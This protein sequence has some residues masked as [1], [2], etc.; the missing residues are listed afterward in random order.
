M[1]LT[2]T[3]T[4]LHDVPLYFRNNAKAKI[5]EQTEKRYLQI[6]R[7]DKED[8]PILLCFAAPGT[9]KSRLAESGAKFLSESK[10]D[11]LRRMAQDDTLA[12]HISFNGNT[13]YDKETDHKASQSLG[14]R[15]LS[16][17]FGFDW[18]ILKGGNFLS[19]LT[20]ESCL[21]AVL[22][23]HRRNF[24]ADAP[25][26]I[27]YLAVDDIGGIYPHRDRET[28]S[29]YLAGEMD[30]ASEF[31]K[32]L[33]NS[34]GSILITPPQN[35]FCVA[36]ITGTTY[37]PVTNILRTS[38]HPYVNV[39]VPLLPLQEAMALV[40]ETGVFPESLLAH[41]EFVRLMAD[42]GGI[43][44]VL[45]WLLDFFS[46]H[47]A[48]AISKELFP[49]LISQARVSVQL[50]FERRYKIDPP[51]TYALM[52]AA[53]LRTPVM[54][55]SFVL[56]E[57]GYTYGDLESNGS[58][59]LEHDQTTNV[60]TVAVPLIAMNLWIKYI[61]ETPHALTKLM[62]SKDNDYFS[63]KNFE[64]FCALYESLLCVMHSSNDK[65]RDVPL[66]EFYRGAR[67]S[68]DLSGTSLLLSSD[69]S[70][71][72]YQA[73][74]RFPDTQSVETRDAFDASFKQLEEGSIIL[75][76]DGA[77]CD[78]LA[79]TEAVTRDGAPMQL[80]RAMHMKHT[81]DNL[82]LTNETI[83]S[84]FERGQKMIAKVLDIPPEQQ[85]SV[86]L[87]NRIVESDVSASTVDIPRSVIVTRDQLHGFFGVTFAGRA[88]AMRNTVRTPS[89]KYSTWRVRGPIL[90]KVLRRM[91]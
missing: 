9:G 79:K 16:S 22:L 33:T 77:K 49:T 65:A 20:L 88:S 60:R 24:P 14:L 18:G 91:R 64:E 38:A 19:G 39:G 58:I 28:I 6:G 81:V 12:I 59:F 41:P 70:Y 63:W 76:A 53:I 72:V 84:E 36:L 46:T 67:V 47:S 62:Q 1:Q 86:F 3:G 82:P 51:Y 5:L 27:L 56:R 11:E 55:S 80:L 61:H 32:Q 2:S 21:Q 15:V 17:Y 90:L 37:I 4:N 69:R 44:R 23:H 7:G 34:V 43:P 85:V 25:R 68:E 66:T 35:S 78:I 42:I 71:D 31:V 73:R 87:S 54:M 45:E 57:D 48:L 74:S 40:Q 50:I 13:K 52:R 75:N 10:N 30:K 83:W 29:P 89:A 26:T 8:N